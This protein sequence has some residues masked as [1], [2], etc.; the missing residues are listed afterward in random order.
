MK[1]GVEIRLR[2]LELAR[3]TALAVPTSDL[4]RA[5]I[6][7]DNAAAHRANGAVDAAVFE[8]GLVPEGFIEEAT[9]V[10]RALYQIGP[11][12]Y[13]NHWRSRVKR[14]LDCLATVKTVK[15]VAGSRDCADLTSE[16]NNLYNE[17]CDFHADNS[18]KCDVETD[19]ARRGATVEVGGPYGGHC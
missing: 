8:D 18:K 17:L 1:F 4:D 6:L 2:N 10:F 16:H 15:A 13:S 7:S 3:E 19:A 12:E 14:M 9:R 5:F 11:S